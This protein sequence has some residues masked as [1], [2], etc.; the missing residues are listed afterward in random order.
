MKTRTVVPGATIESIDD[1]DIVEGPAVVRFEQMLR[2]Y[3][4]ELRNG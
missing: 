2:A 3:F 4:L 1:P